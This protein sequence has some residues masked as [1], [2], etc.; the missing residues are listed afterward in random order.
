MHGFSCGSISWTENRNK[1]L[2]VKLIEYQTYNKFKVIC[3]RLSVHR[4]NGSP[5]YSDGHEQIG[6]WLT[7]SHKAFKP[8]APLHGSMHL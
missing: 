8:Q 6:L 2:K 4:L 5:V 1:I 7:I 3:L